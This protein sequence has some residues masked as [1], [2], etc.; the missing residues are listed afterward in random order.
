VASEIRGIVA[1]LKAAI[2]GINGTGSYVHNLSGT[3]HVRVG[4]PP[5]GGG[6]TPP[7]AWLWI[8]ALRTGYSAELGGWR[9]DLA[10]EIEIRVPASSSDTEERQLIA[11]DALDDLVTALRATRTLGGLVLDSL[12]L[13]SS[14]DG[15]EAG[16]PGCSLVR[17][18]YECWWLSDSTE[19]V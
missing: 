16:I 1:A 3:G 13:G 8:D 10:L 18:R 14:F 12:L 17:A 5:D 4:T 2:V 9:H 19:G 11:T 15:E 7:A 6:P